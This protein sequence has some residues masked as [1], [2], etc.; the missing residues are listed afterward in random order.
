MLFRSNYIIGL[1]GGSSDS[2]NTPNTVVKR[3]G[4]GDFAAGEIT[5]DLVGNVTGQVSDISNHNTDDLSEG[6]SN[7]YFTNQRALDATSAAYDAAGSATNAYNDAIAW[8]Q[9]YTD[10]EISDEV[11]NRNNA[12]SNA[13]T[14]A[15]SYADTVAGNALDSANSYTDSSISTEVTNRNSAIATAKSEAISTASSDATS[16]ANAA[17]ANANDYTDTE[18]AAL[19][20]DRNST[21]LNSSHEWISRMP[22]SA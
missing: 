2:A 22:S 7:K 1:I 9:D 10:G 3:D 8:A 16:K 4:N 20:G 21:R 18:I 11:T 17:L 14:T 6:S 12:I 13:L 5:A 15:E 19:E